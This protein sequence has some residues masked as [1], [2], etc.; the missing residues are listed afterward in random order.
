MI[1]LFGVILLGGA[2]LGVEAIAS[3][4]VPDSVDGKELAR[5]FANC[6]AL[7]G[8]LFLIAAGF[9]C[10]NGRAPAVWRSAGRLNRPSPCNKRGARRRLNVSRS[11]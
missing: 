7:A 1:A 5:S 10:R 11:C 4:S 8:V 9:F 2:G 6:F 3:G